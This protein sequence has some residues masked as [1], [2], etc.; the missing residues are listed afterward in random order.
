MEV[1]VFI[2][3]INDIHH[4]F[5]TEISKL[6]RL[7]PKFVYDYGRFERI[8]VESRI[9]RLPMVI[10]VC[11]QEDLDFVVSLKKELL[12][13]QLIVVLPEKRRDMVSKALSVNP[14]LLSF[15]NN[16]VGHVISLL[17]KMVAPDPDGAVL[18]E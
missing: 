8:L 16:D 14:C 17:E 15:A 11:D 10:L 6:P 4:R 13:A 5:R 12:Q 1:L 2:K 7:A 3:Y 18:S 9:N